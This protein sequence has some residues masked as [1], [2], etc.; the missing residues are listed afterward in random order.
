VTVHVESSATIRGEQEAHLEAHLQDAEGPRVLSSSFFSRRTPSFTRVY[1]ARQFTRTFT[2]TFFSRR[3]FARVSFSRYFSRTFTR[4]F[5]RFFQGNFFARFFVP[6]FTCPRSF[7]ENFM[8]FDQTCKFF[9]RFIAPSSDSGPRANDRKRGWSTGKK[10]A[11]G[12]LAGGAVG[13]YYYLMINDAGAGKAVPE[14]MQNADFFAGDVDLS[15]GLPGFCF[16]LNTSECNRYVRGKL[17]DGTNQDGT[18]Q[19]ASNFLVADAGST[20]YGSFGSFSPPSQPAVCH[21]QMWNVSCALLISSSQTPSPYPT[22]NRYPSPVKSP[23]SVGSAVG[24]TI[25]AAVL[26]GALIVAWQRRAQQQRDQKRV[27]RQYMQ[28][29]DLGQNP[30]LVN[31]VPQ[32]QP[33]VMGYQPPQQQQ[34]VYGQQQ[35]VYV[36][37]TQPGVINPVGVPVTAVVLPVLQTAPGLPPPQ[38]KADPIQAV[39]VPADVEVRG[40]FCA[41]CGTKNDIDGDGV[42]DGKFCN[43]CGNALTVKQ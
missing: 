38:S 40:I 21:D 28:M 25:V 32:Q 30:P 7:F 1:F 36:Q 41:E 26:C 37:Q 11:A 10:V 31:V 13:D 24:G 8:R 6:T 2:R 23:S 4:F 9:A 43:G 17:Q 5:G 35:Q 16:V 34:P 3:F 33:M 39:Q 29:S 22:P 18:N 19:D 15:T 12:V 20:T 14:A 27:G 42:A